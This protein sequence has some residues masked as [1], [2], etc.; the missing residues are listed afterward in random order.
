MLS[1]DLMAW[2]HY[3]PDLRD[4]GHPNRPVQ[5][6]RRGRP[7]WTRYVPTCS[8]ALLQQRRKEFDLVELLAKKV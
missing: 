2:C 6:A 3:L 5:G 7:A 4:Q 1:A 8:P